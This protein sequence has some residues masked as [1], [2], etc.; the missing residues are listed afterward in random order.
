LG[1]PVLLELDEGTQQFVFCFDE[2]DEIE[3]ESWVDV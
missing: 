3:S 1:F 2:L